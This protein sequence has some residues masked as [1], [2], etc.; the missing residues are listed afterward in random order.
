MQRRDATR[1]RTSM[2]PATKTPERND[3]QN[4]PAR[5]GA[6]SGNMNISEWIQRHIS[7]H[8]CRHCS[9]PRMEQL[10]QGPS[11]S[12]PITNVT[13]PV[14]REAILSCV[15]AN[16]STYKLQRA[17]VDFIAVNVFLSTLQKRES[18]RMDFMMWQTSFTVS[19]Q[20]LMNLSSFIMR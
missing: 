15:V 10:V 4:F 19:P 7:A 8:T 1:H 13:I 14:G 11:F 9:L 12:A 18:A 17:S 16:L 2:F 20:S 6:L 5:S 3:I